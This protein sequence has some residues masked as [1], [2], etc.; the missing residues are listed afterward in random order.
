MEPSRKEE[1]IIDYLLGECND[2]EK[3]EAK[4]LV[5]S[6][7]MALGMYQQYRDIVLGANIVYDKKFALS[8]NELIGKARSIT[9]KN[10][11][12]KANFRKIWYGMAASL[13]IG[14]IGVLLYINLGEKETFTTYTVPIGAKGQIDLKDGTRAWI[15]AGSVL[16]YSDFYGYKNRIVYLEGEGYFEVAKNENLTFMVKTKEVCVKALGTKF[17]VKAYPN[18]A[19]I[20]TSL[21]EGSV[22]VEKSKNAEISGLGN[23]LLLEPNQSLVI[24]KQPVLHN[25]Q[26]VTFTVQL[27][28]LDDVGYISSW[29]DDVWSIKSEPLDEL[30]KKLERRYNI[31]IMFSD[32]SLKKIKFT[33]KIKNDPV[34]Q[35]LKAI[36]LTAGIKTH[37]SHNE[38]LIEKDSR[39]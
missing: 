30:A 5:D 28:K 14:A 3:T 13:L 39:N 11:S 21:M 15:N 22:M 23:G 10:K 27:N 36:E 38:V 34:E 19:S 32:E 31:K 6:D 4:K 7:D 2:K 9:N 26:N 35:V 1:L 8:K 18:D 37:I 33:G 29:K 12:V 25:S 20:E 17:N 16:K 24:K